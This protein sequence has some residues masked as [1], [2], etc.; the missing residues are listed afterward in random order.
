MGKSS[1]CQVELFGTWICFR[2]WRCVKTA[3]R[4][5][6]ATEITDARYQ[7]TESAQKNTQK[8]YLPAS[9]CVIMRKATSLRNLSRP[10]TVDFRIVHQISS[11]IGFEQNRWFPDMFGV[12]SFLS[13]RKRDVIVL[14]RRYEV[15]S[16]REQRRMAKGMQ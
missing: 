4:L 1:T 7:K 2:S 3:V 16:K 15:R 6:G 12:S 9:S 13:A 10:R 14:H 5:S 11:L 8:T